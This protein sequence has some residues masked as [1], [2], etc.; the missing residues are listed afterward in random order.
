VRKFSECTA[1]GK[2]THKKRKKRNR[3]NTEQ[4]YGVFMTI[5][6]YSLRV[7]NEGYMIFRFKQGDIAG[8]RLFLAATEDKKR[9]IF[10]LQERH[11][12]NATQ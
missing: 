7:Q 8:H 9:E 2:V 4:K 3:Q 10:I 1:R 5:Q 6:A 11:I 12:K